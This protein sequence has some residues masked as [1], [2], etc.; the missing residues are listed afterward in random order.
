MLIAKPIMWIKSGNF[1]MWITSETNYHV[2]NIL[3][4]CH[5]D[6]GGMIIMWIV[7]VRL[8]IKIVMLITV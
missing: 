8:I 1:I 3:K 4:F 2:D 5:V 6:N 7:C